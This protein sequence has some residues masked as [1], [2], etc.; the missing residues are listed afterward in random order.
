[1]RGADWI[2]IL[3]SLYFAALAW[4]RPLPSHRRTKV[5]AIAVFTLFVTGFCAFG[6]PRLM[7]P[8][9]ASVTR[10]WIPAVL[11]LLVYWEAGAFFVR[12]DQGFQNRLEHFD[13]RHVA[14]FLRWMAH[15]RFGSAIG[16]YLECAYLL[17]YPMIPMCLGALY[18]LHL[19]RHADRFWIVV[20]IS[21]YGSYAV[22]PFLQALPPR[23]LKEEWYAPLPFN[24]VR[25]FNLWI[26]SHASIHA[27][28]FP[29]AHVAASVSAALIILQLAPW[30]VAL[31]FAV[32]A[33]GIAVGTFA[34]RYHY[35]ADSIAGAALA[36]VVFL[37]ETLVSGGLQK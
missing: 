15:S 2:Q 10:D 9:S 31:L 34:G 29:S 33:I 24:P 27:N 35:C 32:I 20:L 19:G 23:M 1:M 18:V 36:T 12:V 25:R 17:C 14:P 7:P 11:V 6:L 8:L 16:V 30:H 26:L 5:T 13:E 21:T 4:V 37:I 3:V 22:L 28:T